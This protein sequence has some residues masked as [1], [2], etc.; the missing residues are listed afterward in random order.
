MNEGW[1]L[2]VETG[3]GASLGLLYIVLISPLGEKLKLAIKQD[4]VLTQILR[5]ALE[6][7]VQQPEK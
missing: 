5:L 4:N 2:K 3:S 7:E 1:S 6:V